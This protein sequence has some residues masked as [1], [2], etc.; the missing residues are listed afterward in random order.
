MSFTCLKLMTHQIHLLADGIKRILVAILLLPLGILL[1]GCTLLPMKN[2]QPV[3]APPSA[4]ACT[5][6]HAM[7]ARESTQ[8][9]YV[10]P[11][12]SAFGGV[13]D[14]EISTAT[15]Y[16]E[17]NNAIQSRVA[18]RLPADLAN[19]RVTNAFREFLTAASGEAQLDAQISDGTLRPESA[20][21]KATISKE[22]A[23]IQKHTTLPNL[24]QSELKDFS[25]KL[26]ELQLRHGPAD[27]IGTNTNLAVL[28]PKASAFAASRPKLGS[29]LL[30]YLKAYYDGKFYDRFGTA[31]SKPQLSTPPSA[32][33]SM[34]FSVPDSEIV[35]A[36]TVLLE[37]LVDTMDPT[38]VMGDSKDGLPADT[39]YYPG[40]SKNEPTAL[41]SGLAGYA[42]LPA[43]S[44]NSV[45][46]ITTANVWVLKDLANAASDNAAAVGGLVVNTPGGISIGLGIVG[47]ISIGDNQTLSDLVKTAAA[48][49]ALRA[50]LTTSYFTL[51]NVSF[52]PPQT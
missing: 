5:S 49:L 31:I 4:G 8:F 38:P 1:S 2:L 30:V 39:T 17:Y 10:L 50:A 46:G 22:H 9:H 35:A 13:R 19:H 3:I 25:R 26:F 23:S 16:E 6:G 33:S 44:N 32:S 36:E 14:A 43:D 52:H 27:Y 15:N 7:M 12:A 34:N 20:T 28:G 45:C 47:K 41:A 37:F 18:A 40:A 51:R 24:K 11:I 42:M 48:E 29:E 21:D